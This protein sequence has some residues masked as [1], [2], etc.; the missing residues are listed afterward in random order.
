MLRLSADNAAALSCELRHTSGPF[1]AR[2]RAV[3]VL[4]LAASSVMGLITLYQTG[5]LRHL[6]EPQLSGL[7]ADTVD[8]AP[9]AYAILATPDAA[10]GLTSYAVTIVLAA[11]GRSDRAVHQPWVPLALAGKVGFDVL[12]GLKLTWDQWS[13]HRAFCSWCLLGS[14]ASFVSFPLVVPEARAALARLR[15]S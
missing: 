15:Q 13:K 5:I 6:P 2:R 1:L 3:I 12:V 14:L 7:D 10:L 9:E 4:S 11:M 8:A